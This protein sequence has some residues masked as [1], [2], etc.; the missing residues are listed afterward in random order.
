MR[1]VVRI[2]LVL[3]IDHRANLIEWKCTGLA[4]VP[5][6]VTRPLAPGVRPTEDPKLDIDV[7]AAALLTL[8]QEHVEPF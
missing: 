7:V 5:P 1:N 3:I 8:L 2:E 6:A 4:G